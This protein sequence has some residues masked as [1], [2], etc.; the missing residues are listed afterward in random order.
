MRRLGATKVQVGFQSLNDDVLTLNKR[1]HDVASIA[2]T[3]ERLRQAGFKVHAHWMLNLKGSS[4][5]A[6]KEDFDRVVGD[7]RFQPDE[8]KVYPCSLVESAE[9]MQSYEDGSWAPYSQSELMEVLGHVVKKTPRFC[10]ITRMI[11]DIPAT[12]IVV[13][14]RRANLRQDVEAAAKASVEIRS[15]EVR[16]DAP[17]RE[18][19]ALKATAYKTTTSREVFLEWV[20]AEDR[21]AG[22][23]RLSLPSTPSFVDELVGSAIIREVHVYGRAVSVGKRDGQAPQHRGLGRGLVEEA[24]QRAADAGFA[25]IAVI[26]S[27]GTKAY[28][29]K[30]GF[31][32]GVLYQHRGL[33]AG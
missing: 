32:D 21:I 30:L 19:L 24:C 4:P 12:D 14:S 18:A 17:K 10:R 29:R 7:P 11:R 13:G 16:G 6:D 20:T 1:G 8:L 3:V 28:Y 9:L 5:Q 33:A 25:S 27:I 15:R 31:E 23:L 2:K 22:F 26:S